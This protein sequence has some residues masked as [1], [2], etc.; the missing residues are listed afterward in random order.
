MPSDTGSVMVI[1]AGL[2][3]LTAAL[4][5]QRQGWRVRVFEQAPALG[6]VGAGISLSAGSGQGLAS[7]GLGDALL[8]ASGPIPDIA[9][10]HYRT[11]ALLAGR[12]ARTPPPDQGFDTSRHIHRADLHAILAAA[13]RAHD[14]EAVVTGR[15]LTG[16]KQ[17]SGG[18]TAH[19]ADGETARADLMLGADGSRSSVRRALFD[20]APP[21]FAGQIAYRCLVPRAQA[22][23]F[24]SD[25]G[26]VVYVGAA[27]VFNR[28]LLRQGGLLNVVGIAR[29]EAWPDEGWNIRAKVA[30]F[31]QAFEAFHPDVIGLIELAP[32]ETLIK[33]GLFV[34]PP[35]ERWSQGRVLLIGDAA[36]PILP[37]LGL[38][39]ALAIEDGVMLA[40]VLSAAADHD[41]AFAAFHKARLERVEAVRSQSILQGQIIQAS[42]PDHT[43][44]SQSPSQRPVLFDYDPS[45]APLHV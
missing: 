3:G 7:L 13:V 27:R 41:V 15:R 31:A 37:F 5:L 42:D 35:L 19:F 30:E 14:P 44:L 43:H 34:R 1:G 24:L 10:V 40:R 23:P 45:T 39:A 16:L 6:E 28:Y 9:F 2:G 36:H 11:A 22:E 26:A 33:W 32:P 20:D 18:V 38:G 25:G 4:A 21:Q 8:A 12:F 29:T 17:D